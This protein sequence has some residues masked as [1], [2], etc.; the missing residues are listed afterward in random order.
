MQNTFKKGVL[1]TYDKIYKNKKK[2]LGKCQA[3][4]YQ[5]LKINRTNE[6]ALNATTLNQIKKN[7]LFI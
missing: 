3:S 1:I 5:K 6:N 7:I 4:L 2:R